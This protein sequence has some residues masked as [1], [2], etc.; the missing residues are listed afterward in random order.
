MASSNR[1]QHDQE[2]LVAPV[3]FASESVE[4]QVRSWRM[5]QAIKCG[6]SIDEAARFADGLGDLELLRRLSAAGCEGTVA[7]RIAHE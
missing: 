2:F 5:E 4:A 3:E 7:F 6:L 1:S